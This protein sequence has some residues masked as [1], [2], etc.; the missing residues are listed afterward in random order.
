MPK[1]RGGCFAFRLR[2][3]RPCLHVAAPG[4]CDR[5]P[6][7]APAPCTW[8]QSYCPH[9]HKA[10]KELGDVTNNA[11]VVGTMQLDNAGKLGQE[12][13]AEIKAQFNHSVSATAGWKQSGCGTCI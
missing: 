6:R 3:L 10:I 12:V 9:C 1:G 7:R 11:G 8:A 2:D 13:Q 4:R 5:Q